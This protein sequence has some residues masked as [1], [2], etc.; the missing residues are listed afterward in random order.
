MPVAEEQPRPQPV[1]LGA[2][3]LA[4]VGVFNAGRVAYG[5]MVNLSQDDWDSG[6]RAVFLVL[7]SIVLIFALFILVLAWQVRRGRLW[8]WIVSLVILPFTILFGALLLLI[9]AVG[10]AFPLAG[11]G[12]VLAAMA[13]LATLTIPR[14]VRGYFVRKPAPM[15]PGPV[16][17]YPWGPGYPPQ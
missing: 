15:M 16:P 13:A 5:V 14:T 17:N 1:E 4:L 2:T 6:A 10:G 3:L 11:I 7:N 8:A 9:T 12:I